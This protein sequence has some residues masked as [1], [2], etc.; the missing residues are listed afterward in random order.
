MSQTTLLS[1]CWGRRI[2]FLAIALG[3][4]LVLS[5][6]TIPVIDLGPGSGGI[7]FGVAPATVYSCLP[8]NHG[9][10]VGPR[11]SVAVECD[12]LAEFD[13]RSGRW[14]RAIVL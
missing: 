12:H 6:A 4:P 11:R 10:R 13:L 8:T 5:A 3:I 7:T 2:F 1:S 9:Q 14:R